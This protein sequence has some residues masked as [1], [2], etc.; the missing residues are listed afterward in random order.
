MPSPSLAEWIA[1]W[2][3][4]ET[5]MIVFGFAWGAMLGS[6]INVVVHRIPLGASIVTT[7]SRCP[8]CGTAIRPYDNVPVLGW[9]WL[10]GRCRSCRE[11]IAATYPLVEAGCGVIVMVLA[12]SELV[13]GG[14]WLPAYANEYP[15]GIDRLLRGDW[16]LLATCFL[17]AA[18]ALT[19]VTWSLLDG[20]GWRGCAK[21]A[22]L[23]IVLAVTAVGIVPSASPPA[24]MTGLVLPALASSLVGVAAGALLGLAGRGQGVRWG[25]PLLGSVLGWQAV[26]L[27]A[28][29]TA[30][31]TLILRGVFG[32]GPASRSGLVL[33]AVGTLGLAMGHVVRP[34]VGW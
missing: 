6:F 17:H 11:P 33:A 21:H 31:A 3:W 30:V 22:T 32:P 2:P 12:A 26:T 23:A 19:V 9:L 14:R 5:C 13:G 4:A 24:I 16:W 10:G 34:F 29:V 27:V 20:V 18:V 1:V 15:V 28:L 7:P 8:T 25:L